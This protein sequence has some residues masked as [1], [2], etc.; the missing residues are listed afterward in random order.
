MVDVLG[1]KKVKYDKES[2]KTDI[3]QKRERLLSSFVANRPQNW[4]CDSRTKE[5]ISIS[6]WLREEMLLLSLDELG[7]KTQEGEFNR[8]SRSVEDLYD[9]AANIM[10]DVLSDNINRN[11]RPHRRWG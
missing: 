10:N 5:L 8:I 1:N 2:V 3:E 6:T 4:S 11:R 7:R 9:L